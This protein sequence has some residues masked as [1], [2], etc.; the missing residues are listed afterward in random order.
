MTH[1]SQE[2]GF[3]LIELV[4]VMLLL[5]IIAVTF[6]KIF[7]QGLI[8]ANAEEQM[9]DA[10]WQGQ[11]IMQRIVRDLRMIR[12]AND[13]TTMTNDNLVFT[14]I[15]G[16]SINYNHNGNSELL[17]LNGDT[18]SSGVEH[19]TFYYKTS[20]NTTTT[21]ASNL[22]YIQI[23]LEIN[24]DGTDYSLDSSVYLRDLSS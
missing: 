13:I 17:T 15:L 4:M 22:A 23:T 10:A 24:L 1:R 3:T 21:T 9:S 18:L 6:N 20:A 19:L 16:S 7:I 12:S 14:N 11:M 5:G 2:S 8:T